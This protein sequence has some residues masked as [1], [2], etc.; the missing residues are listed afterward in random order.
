MTEIV[1]PDDF[2]LYKDL[3][4][5][6]DDASMHGALINLALSHIA[7]E[8]RAIA[9]FTEGDRLTATG[10]WARED[11][12]LAVDRL[13]HSADGYLIDPRERKGFLRPFQYLG[14]I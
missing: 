12:H 14:L 5:K 2:E 6:P 13:E 11:A 10:V 1:R 7:S 8:K 3:Y 9:I 4:I